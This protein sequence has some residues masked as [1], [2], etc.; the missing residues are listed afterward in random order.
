M[1]VPSGVYCL[2]RGD[3]PEQAKCQAVYR[4]CEAFAEGAIR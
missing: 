4:L 1:H 3:T 2:G